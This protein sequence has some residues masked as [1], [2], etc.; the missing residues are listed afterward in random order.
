MIKFYSFLLVT[1]FV[2]ITFSKLNAQNIF[3]INSIGTSAGSIGIGNIEGF[4]KSANT[5]FENPASLFTISTFSIS[6]FYSEFLMGD[7]KFNSISAAYRFPFGILGIGTMKLGIDTI[8]YTGT[9]AFNEF[10]ELSQFAYTD[11][12]TKLSFQNSLSE[13]LNWGISLVNYSKSLKDLSGS[14]W[15]VDSGLF[16]KYPQFSASFTARNIL[17]GQKMIYS[18]GSK[19][20]LPL[21]IVCGIS[22]KLGWFDIYGQLKTGWSS[23]KFLKSIGAKFQ[24][25][26][27]GDLFYL[28][29]GISESE[30]FDQIKSN[31]SIGTGLDLGGIQTH[32]AYQPSEYFGQFSQYYFS[33][34]INF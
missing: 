19:E 22:G 31:F 32:F 4:S 20:N 33:A 18:N 21:Q 26:F 9:N 1:G 5:L 28:S 24:P 3:P 11:Q 16:L 30:V 8:P 2:L 17:A 12:W 23:P 29:S 14:G 27:L 6:G 10:I 13:E 34:A 15:N 25:K 7:L